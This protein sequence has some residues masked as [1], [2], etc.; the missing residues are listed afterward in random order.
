MAEAMAEH[1]GG[2]NGGGD[3]GGDDS[4][5]GKWGETKEDATLHWY[6]ACL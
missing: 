6:M 1:N 3:S 2:D 4:G 5:G